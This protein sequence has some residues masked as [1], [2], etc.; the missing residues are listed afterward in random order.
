MF[1]S[2]LD[3]FVNFTCQDPYPENTKFKFATLCAS[4]AVSPPLTC[5]GVREGFCVATL[6]AA[7]RRE[8]VC[9]RQLRVRS[10][11]QRKATLRK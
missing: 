8:R 2:Y 10:T 1:I 11:T 5:S 4:K 7:S 3:K 9:L 6:A